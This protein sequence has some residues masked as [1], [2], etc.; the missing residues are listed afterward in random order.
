[1]AKTKMKK[2]RNETKQPILGIDRRRVQT[3]RFML[4]TAL[5]LLSGLITLITRKAFKFGTDGII[6]MAPIITT[7]KSSTFHVFLR[8]DRLC[9]TNPNAVILKRAS[10]MKIAV[11][12]R[13]IFSKIQ[14]HSVSFQS[15]VQS[16]MASNMLLPA[17]DK[18]M[19]QSKYLFEWSNII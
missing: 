9:T 8:Q 10:N 16:V 2:R 7:V 5:I 1:M 6:E 15:S 13:S 12:P 4:G 17:I 19:K 18:I 3:S 11:K 14:F